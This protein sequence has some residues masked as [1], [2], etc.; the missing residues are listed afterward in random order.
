MSQ[1][2][3]EEIILLDGSEEEQE[4][5]AQ[6]EAQAALKRSKKKRLIIIGAAAG[7]VLLLALLGFFIFSGEEELVVERAKPQEKPL[8]ITQEFSTKK[9]DEM[10]KKANLL[11]QSGD[12][13]AALIL[14]EQISVY[15]ERLS[16]YNLG[17]SELRQGKYELALNSFKRALELGDQV[18]VSAINAA[19]CALELKNKALHDYYIDLAHSKLPNEVKSPLYN[20]Y[21]GLINY[22]KGFYP[23]ALQALRKV[24]TPGYTQEAS[25]L[26]ARILL[27]LGYD[28]DALE[29]GATGAGD[30]ARGLIHA[31]LGNW[32]QA[33]ALLKR[34]STDES[35]DLNY[36][37]QAIT[38]VEL[39]K[40][41]YLEAGDKLSAMPK[42][43]KLL[44]I[45][46]AL[47]KNLY[48]P[49]LIQDNF[50]QGFIRQSSFEI[51]FY[52]SP[53]RVFDTSSLGSL[54]NKGSAILH[55]QGPGE[56]YLQESKALSHTNNQMLLAVEKA[57]SFDLL[58]ANAIFE[59]LANDYSKHAI[60]QYNLALSY[61]LLG[62]FELAGKRFTASFHL[63]PK[64]HLS[65]LYALMCAKLTGSPD[66]RLEEEVF[67]SLAADSANPRIDF[68]EALAAFILKDYLRAAERIRGNSSAKEPLPQAFS[69]TP[70]Y[71]SDAVQR[72]ATALDFA[73]SALI[74]YENDRKEEAINAAD[75]LSSLLSGDLVANILGFS[76]RNEGQNIKAYAHSAQLYFAQRELDRVSLFSSASLPT[77]LYTRLLQLAGLLGH[78]KNRI[79]AI[80]QTATENQAQILSSLAHVNLY[81]GSFEEAY[82][83][84]NSLIDTHKIKDSHTLFLASVAAIGAGHTHEAIA[85]LELSRIEDSKS[86]EARA[87]LGLL[88]LQTQKIEP[89]IFQFRQ[90]KKN[91]NSEFFTFYMQ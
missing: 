59:E 82:L 77:R 10:L 1:E 49:K 60:L 36:V 7:L 67:A 87:A 15:N 14:Y 16:D 45:T 53:F 40:G 37:Q 11:Y 47:N 78:E 32:D 12:K 26:Q 48:D 76:L 64:D 54:L 52:F 63:N 70:I 43:A 35:N 9:L 85:L 38:L 28:K 69:S 42:D 19:V 44:P 6:E 31:R 83:I 88:Y 22:Y 84:Y 65:G 80:L 20:Y 46:V 61:A 2:E 66:R 56:E 5:L 71:S 39:K 8:S 25:L 27:H 79:N 89:A 91:F 51:I 50:D 74:F 13:E 68:Y 58:G 55:L 24:Q 57:L 72:G 3:S 90:I 81:A 75:S 23:E 4:A 33:L 17:V 73:L 21:L 62:R 30:L 86:Y 18:T 41:S 29:L 34:A